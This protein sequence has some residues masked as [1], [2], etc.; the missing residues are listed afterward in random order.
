[1]LS[2]PLILALVFFISLSALF[3][4][5]SYSYYAEKQV[6]QE[7]LGVSEAN[8]KLLSSAIERAEKA[9]VISD[10]VVAEYVSESQEIVA[11]KDDVLERLDKLAAVVV[12]PV[13]QDEKNAIQTTN[14]VSLGG[15]LPP[16]LVGLLAEAC[17]RS[18]GVACNDS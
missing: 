6:L 12:E 1:M 16:S 14:F 7:R 3:G 17:I 11:A 9:H 8:A 5:I 18:K 15:R 10:K 2:K 4:Y 13:K